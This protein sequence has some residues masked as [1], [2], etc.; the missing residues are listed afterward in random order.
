MSRLTA[1]AILAG[2]A[3]LAGGGTAVFAQSGNPGSVLNQSSTLLKEQ[4]ELDAR[5]SASRA[6]LEEL[7]REQ[8]QLN[9]QSQ[10]LNDDRQTNQSLCGSPGTYYAMRAECDQQSQDLSNASQNLSRQQRETGQRY[11]SATS[12]ADLL[13]KRQ[14]RLQE[15]AEDMKQKLGRMELSGATKDC[16]ER[17]KR[18]DLNAS[19]AAYQKCLDGTGGAQSQLR[20]E[21]QRFP[22]LDTPGPIEQMGI[23]DEKRRKRKA[24]EAERGY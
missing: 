5:I 9:Q 21:Q 8:Q 23:E 1:M 18:D 17:L 4:Q 12:E 11:Q 16:V 19:V 22:S 13:K 14:E 7:K 3:L 6:R 24:R 15:Q 20:P 10:R 2:S